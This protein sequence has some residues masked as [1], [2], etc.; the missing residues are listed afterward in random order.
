MLS[1]IKINMYF[2]K[3]FLTILASCALTAVASV[4]VSVQVFMESLCPDTRNFIKYHLAPVMET[5]SSAVDLEL[6]I[7]GKTKFKVTVEQGTYLI[8]YC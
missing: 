5:M 6:V 1:A 2:F 8:G 7:F 4:P 3:I